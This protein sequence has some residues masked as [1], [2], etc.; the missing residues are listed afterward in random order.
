MGERA[1]TI[2]S[3]LSLAF[4]IAPDL[5][6]GL[7]RALAAHP[8]FSQVTS[9][10]FRAGGFGDAG[11]ALLADAL[12]HLPHLTHLSLVDCGVTARGCEKLAQYLHTDFAHKD[13]RRQRPQATDVY[14]T[15]SDPDPRMLTGA[16]L[17]QTL[18]R[19]ASIAAAARTKPPKAPKPAEAAKPGPGELP[20]PKKPAPKKPK[21]KKAS[22]A[23]AAAAAV[24]AAL[25][26]SSGRH[27][28]PLVALDLS[29]NPIGDAGARHLCRALAHS[30]VIR[31]LRLDFCGLTGVG[32][33]DVAAFTA[34]PAVALAQLSLR[35]NRLGVW[36][37]VALLQGLW[38]SPSL[39][40]LDLG[41]TQLCSPIHAAALDAYMVTPQPPRGVLAN[42]STR[43][44][45]RRGSANAKPDETLPETADASMASPTVSRSTSLAP[46]SPTAAAAAAAAPVPEP[47]PEDDEDL[48]AVLGQEDYLAILRSLPVELH[49]VATLICVVRSCPV[50]AHVK[51]DGN[52]FGTRGAQLVLDNLSD[53]P[54]VRDFTLDARVDTVVYEAIQK[55]LQRNMPVRKLKK[56]KKPLFPWSR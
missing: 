9:L 37:G 14:G 35:G 45:K 39:A 54:Y 5:L 13:R 10:A 31:E 53:L 15:T 33:L 24:T 4:P 56:K 42:A 44:V 27:V 23:A 8:Q 38:G 50:L 55:W 29:H 25:H 34:T 6:Y 11:A 22:A 20:K 40:A 1:P 2:P 28:A 26:A 12:P 41:A 49:C 46:A 18:T 48:D 52:S 3:S 43:F 17:P 51:V 21:T 36:G 16:P 7:V 47:L 19:G 30:P 32:A